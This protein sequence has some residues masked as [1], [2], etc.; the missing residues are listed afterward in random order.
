MNESVK[1][2]LDT[3]RQHVPTDAAWIP[4][5]AA[6]LTA[7]I[8]LVLL[9]RGARLA[10]AAIAIAFCVAGGYT[11]THVASA[12]GTPLWPTVAAG[13]VIGLVAGV[14]FFRL[15]LAGIVAAFLA[16]GALTFYGA[17]VL[18]GPL[19]QYGK[20]E[21]QGVSLPPAPMSAP[22]DWAS[23]LVAIVAPLWD[24]L[25]QQVPTFHA[26]FYAIV[27][28][29]GLGGLVFGLL[30]PRVARAAWAATLGTALLLAG[31]YALLEGRWAQADPWFARWGT[32]TAGSMWS[33]AL[34]YN[35]ADMVGWRPRRPA[36]RAPQRAVA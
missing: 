7:L 3:L 19:A 21:A 13:S 32:L 25:C 6:G 22:A 2:L 31:L 35:L 29:T 11:G 33:V 16:A 36:A 28:S 9:L 23:R 10:P 30:L 24:Y 15:W 26:S 5:A 17:Q 8:G 27:I 20:V 34:L 18:T 4:L 1:T 12:F 14:L